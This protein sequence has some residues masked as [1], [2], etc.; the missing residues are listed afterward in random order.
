MSISE[1]ISKLGIVI[2]NPLIR[3]MF[4]VALVS[5]L[6]GVA[7]YIQNADD[8]AERQKGRMGILYGIIGLVIMVSVY[9][10]MAIAKNTV[11]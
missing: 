2:I 1:F 6:W 8:P 5:F 3:L 4:A 11:F 9:S 7:K 10:I